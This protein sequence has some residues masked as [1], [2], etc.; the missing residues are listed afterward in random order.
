MFALG[1]SQGSLNLPAK[2]DILVNGRRN[3]RAIVVQLWPVSCWKTLASPM[4][5]F[6]EHVYFMIHGSQIS[7]LAFCQCS[8][9]QLNFSFP[10]SAVYYLSKKIRSETNISWIGNLSMSTSIPV[11]ISGMAMTSSWSASSR[12]SRWRGR[13][14]GRPQIPGTAIA[15]SYLV[16][17]RKGRCSVVH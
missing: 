11:V 10:Q 1:S 15:S 16:N 8:V 14:G 12:G 17:D 3:T 4:M 9:W 13:R 6:S 7:L 2:V 5:Y